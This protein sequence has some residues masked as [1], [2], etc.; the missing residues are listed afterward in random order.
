[1]HKVQRIVDTPLSLLLAISS[2]HIHRKAVSLRER[3]LECSRI[4]APLT[5]IPRRDSSHPS[6]AGIRFGWGRTDD[7]G[8]FGVAG[9]E[10]YGVRGAEEVDRR[11]FD[12]RGAVHEAPL[13]EEDELEAVEGVLGNE[14]GP[15]RDI[16]VDIIA[17]DV[18]RGYVFGVGHGLIQNVRRY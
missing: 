3:S 13:V 18:V 8:T 7:D 15:G 17:F 14:V 9:V 2:T 10:V 4:T 12:G 5:R 11:G 16:G 1:V 6:C